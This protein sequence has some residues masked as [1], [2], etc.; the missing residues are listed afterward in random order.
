MVI[1]FIHIGFNQKHK[2]EDYEE[3]KQNM[4]AD[5]NCAKTVGNNAGLPFNFPAIRLWRGV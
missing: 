3:N 5:D 4:F 1:V 2:K